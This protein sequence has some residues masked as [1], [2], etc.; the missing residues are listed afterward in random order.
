MKK[1]FI[2]IWSLVLIVSNLIAQSTSM[3]VDLR[4][5][6]IGSSINSLHV[7]KDYLYFKGTDGV[8]LHSLWKCDGENYPEKLLP[9]FHNSLFNFCTYNSKLLFSNNSELWSYDGINPPSQETDIILGS[10]AS[11]LSVYHDTLFFNSVHNYYGNELFF[12]D[13]VNNAELFFD[14]INGGT[15]SSPSNYTIYNDALYFCPI[16]G[17]FNLW[18]YNGDTIGW[19]DETKNMVPNYLFVYDGQLFFAG[20]KNHGIELWKYNSID[21]TL[22]EFDIY[23]DSV[24][25][26]DSTSGAQYYLQNDSYPKGFCEY[27]DTLYFIARDTSS[28][29]LMIW[30][31]HETSGTNMAKHIANDYTEFDNLIFFDNSLFFTC[32]DNLHGKELWKYNHSTGAQLVHDIAVG[33]AGSEPLYLTVFN[34]KLYF[35]ANDRQAYGR[36]LWVYD[37]LISNINA[38]QNNEIVV[39]FPNPAN[40]FIF[41]KLSNSLLSKATVLDIYDSRGTHLKTDKLIKTSG[42]IDLTNFPK[43]VYYFKLTTESGK[44]CKK[45]ILR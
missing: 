34:N 7:Y 10:G 5:G 31:Y 42:Y 20:R 41:Y 35:T 3:V 37:P 43:G 18:C 32:N 17:D 21:Q 27:T 8:D 2:L 22:I 25:Y 6:S 11:Q 14:I 26:Y 15:Y 40:D 33:N 39:L 23:P 13:G 19:L 9:E 28:P 1:K 45:I 36:E 12:Y 16:S 38:M 29:E 4:P 44:E 24:F 30:S